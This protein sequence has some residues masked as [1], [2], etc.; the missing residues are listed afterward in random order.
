MIPSPR[1]RPSRL[2]ACA[3]ALLLLA[4][5]CGAGRAARRLSSTAAASSAPSTPRTG[6]SPAQVRAALA[7]T[8]ADRS[9]PRGPV[10]RGFVPVS[11]T[12]ISAREFWLL[13]TAPCPRP[14]C[15]SIV[16]TTDGG[17]HFVGLPAPVAPLAGAGTDTGISVLRFADPLSGFAGPAGAPGRLWETHDGGR[18]WSPG[19]S[20]VVTFTVSGGLVYAVAGRISAGLATNLRLLTSPADA[21]RWRSTALPVSSSTAL[22]SLTAYG[23]SLWLSLSPGPGHP[24]AQTLLASSDGG[25]T[26][27]SLASPCVPGLGGEIEAASARVLWAVCPTGMMAGAW[28]SVDAGSHWAQL[29]AGAGNGNR[30]AL[31][32]GAKIA[33]AGVSTAVLSPGGSAGLL[34]TTDGGRSFV[35]V[36]APAGG[37]WAWL[38]FTD[39]ST[40]SALRF[41]PEGP[42]GAGHL[43][44]EQLWRSGDGGARWR[45]PVRIG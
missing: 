8:I 25:R 42:V 32:N 15:T 14:V 45:G 34:R 38:G 10:P 44:P 39:S 31:S 11:F 40:G 9:G 1:S 43:A 27:T 24:P 23:S 2:T 13:G 16:R 33:A 21:D 3:A 28:R 5:G 29:P 18:R 12:A 4:G 26:F 37:S 30:L 36:S 41:G 6:P 20:G 17:A 19:P 35:P 22:L 7:A